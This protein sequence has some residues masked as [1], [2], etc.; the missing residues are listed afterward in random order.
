MHDVVVSGAD[1]IDGAGAPARRADVSVGD[2]RISAI[3]HD[4]GEARRVIDAKGQIVAPGFIDIHSHSDFT[5]PVNQRAESKVRQGV[6]TEVVG[7]CGFSVAPALPGRVETLSQY[8]GASAPWLPFRELTFSEY[9]ETF[10]ATSLN[11]VFQVGHNTL[12][13]MAIGMENRAASADEL[14]LM[15]G[16]LEEAL[17]AGALG[18]SSG[19]FTAPGSFAPPEELIALGRVL[20]RH[21]ASYSSHVRNEA[22]HVFD[23]VTEAIRVGE[24][25]DIHVQLSHLKLSGTDTWGGAPKLLA[26]IAA[27]RKRGVRVDCDQYPYTTATNPLRNLLPTWVQDGGITAML[28]RLREK[29]TRA[30]IRDDIARSGLASFGRVPSWDAVCIAMSPRRNPSP[31]LG[32]GRARSSMPRVR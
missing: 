20:G 2:G 13:L 5:L 6:T 21:G 12:R 32:N 26:M 22:D 14:R 4:L 10:P 27:A 15:E 17:E 23:A 3:G 8:L 9:I 29:A 25:C 18:L 31:R 7:N 11:A 30:R 16:L 28:D 24:D 1:V 19:L